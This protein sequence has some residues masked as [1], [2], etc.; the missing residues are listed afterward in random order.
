MVFL[1]KCLISYDRVTF[2]AQSL[3]RIAKFRKVVLR[4][5]FLQNQ[6]PIKCYKRRSWSDHVCRLWVLP[7]GH[8]PALSAR[9]TGI[10]WPTHASQSNDKA[11]SSEWLVMCIQYL[12]A[13]NVSA[14][15]LCSVRYPQSVSSLSGGLWRISVSFYS[16][17][18]DVID[19]M[20]DIFRRVSRPPELSGSPRYNP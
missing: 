1:T 2:T 19:I 7:D 5:S 11:F 18:W 4:H 14:G 9:H 10:E 16:A 13:V 17:S 20:A 3:R 12:T 15:D 8:L 6:R